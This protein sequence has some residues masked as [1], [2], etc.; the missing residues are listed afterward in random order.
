MVHNG[1]VIAGCHTGIGTVRYKLST[2][3]VQEGMKVGKPS[4]QQDSSLLMM[5]QYVLLWQMFYATTLAFVKTSICVT[6]LRIATGRLYILT[7]RF[8]IAQSV[9]LSTVGFIVVLVQC[10]PVKAFWIPS[11]GTCMDKILPTILTYAAS[12]SNVLTDFATALIP[13]LLVRKLQMRS[14]LK[15]YAQLIMCLGVL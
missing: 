7:L 4:S 15:L 9:L 5:S 10:R 11:K 12:V 3:Q 14:R 2:A 8:L 1:I 6:V 13:M